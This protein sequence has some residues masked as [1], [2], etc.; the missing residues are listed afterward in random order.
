MPQP[1]TQRTNITDII[2]DI[3]KL[4][5]FHGDLGLE[6]AQTKELQNLLSTQES[7]SSIRP[8]AHTPSLKKQA[9]QPEIIPAKKKIQRPRVAVS[10]TE[11]DNCAQLIN[12]C[13]SCPH[14]KTPKFGIG[15]TNHPFIFIICDKNSTDP[16]RPMEE[17]EESLLGKMLHAIKIK[18]HQVFVTNLIK[19]K[20]DDNSQKTQTEMAANCLSH[21]KQQI[22]L[23]QPSM[24]CTMGQLSSQ[25]I[26]ESNNQLMALRGHF[27][28]FMDI[29]L[30]ATYHPSQLIAVA[31]LKKATWYD[32]QMMQRRLAMGEQETITPQA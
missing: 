1:I 23:M 17:A 31:E 30:M 3:Q 4:T 24:I 12:E 8:S 6:Y 32:L 22:R 5:A 16:S 2:Q 14:K 29:P 11:I 13:N 10:Q 28:N 27:H 20:I 7:T 9:L 26:L 18:P 19:C 21:T 15:A 25:T